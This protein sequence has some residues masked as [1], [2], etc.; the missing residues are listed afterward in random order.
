MNKELNN[1]MVENKVI[2]PKND[3]IAPESSKK[4]LKKLELLSFS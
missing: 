4:N 2:E 1:N 3:E